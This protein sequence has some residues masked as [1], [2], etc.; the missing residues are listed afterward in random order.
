[1][2]ITLNNIPVSFK[3]E[4]L[5]GIEER[6][7]LA[8]VAPTTRIELGDNLLTFSL[9][10]QP[11][12][13]VA[14]TTMSNL[15]GEGEV[16]PV[17]EGGGMV[18]ARAYK[19][20]QIIPVSAEYMYKLP[21]LYDE[22]IRQA[23]ETVAK[24][25]D[26]EAFASTTAHD[27]FAGLN[28]ANN[29]YAAAAT[30]DTPF[31]QLAA[32]FGLVA[33]NGYMPNAMIASPA[34]GVALMTMTANDGHTVFGTGID[35]VGRVFGAQVV[36]SGVL[37]G[38]APQAIVGDFSQ[39]RLGFVDDIRIKILEEATLTTSNGTLNLAQQNMIGVLVEGWAAFMC[40]EGAFARIG[41]T[42]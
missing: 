8:Q 26:Y 3:D 12:P 25:V 33:A 31:E 14:G 29:D 16:K 21:R 22:I 1:M 7:A 36:T 19:F 5:A 17:G 13:I 42:E 34:E 24:G 27:G 11:A 37:G 4:L 30:G 35:G 9:G 39:S 32:A 28:V 18:T 23:P 15:P 40:A 6:S 38:T 20:A 10:L 2:A 41:G